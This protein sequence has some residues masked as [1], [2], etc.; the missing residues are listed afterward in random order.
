MN[1]QLQFESDKMIKFEN[2]FFEKFNAIQKSNILEFKE[3]RGLFFKKELAIERIENEI[4]DIR[5]IQKSF[6][7]SSHINLESTMKMQ[8]RINLLEYEKVDLNVY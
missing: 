6:Q 7:S 4:I 8:D 3:M 1:E 2:N 5:Y